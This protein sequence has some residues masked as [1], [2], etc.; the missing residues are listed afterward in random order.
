M[1]TFLFTSESVNE[2]HPDKLCDQ[3]SDAVLDACLAQDPDSKVACETCTKTN[4]V[5]VFGEIT[6][7]ANVDYEKIVRDTCRSIGFTSA[8][9]GLDADHC[10]VLV[11]IEQQS[12]DIAQGVHGH[13]TK[14]PEEIGAGDQGHMF[15]YATDETP[16]LMPLSHVLATKLGAKLTEVRKNGTC[17]WLRPDGKTQVTVEYYNENGAMVPVRVHTVLIS[18][19]HDETVTND[20]IAADLKQHVIKPVIPDKYLDDK[21]IFHLNPSGRFVIGGPHGDA[22]LTG[23]KIIID[24]YG[25]WGAHGGG[26]FSGKD[27]TKVDRSGAYIVRQAAKSIVASGLARRCIV[28]VSYAIGVPEPLSVFVDSYGTGKIPDKEILKIV[29]ENFDFRPGMISINLDLKRGG[30]GRFLKTAAY[31]H[32]GRDDPDF[33]WEIGGQLQKSG[34]ERGSKRSGGGSANDDGDSDNMRGHKLE[35]GHS[36]VSNVEIEKSRVT[37]IANGKE[38]TSS[39]I[40]AFDASKLQKLRNKGSKKT[41]IVVSKGSKPDPKKK[42]TKKNRVWDD[43]PPESKLDFTDPAGGNGSNIEVEAT[44]H[45]ENLEPALKSLKNRLMTKNVAEEIVEKLCESVAA[46]L[47][48]KKLASFT[49][50]SSIVQA[51]ME[52]ALVRILTPRRSIDILRDVLMHLAPRSKR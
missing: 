49:M 1:E 41:D 23:R 29:K 31:G 21:T 33:T 17:P 38:N 39:N 20:E 10:K 14:R 4:M 50:I 28:Q 45:G 52:E 5:M 8:D 36:N 43:S 12:P 26:A 18:T 9:V 32:F 19:Q 6:T 3:V 24:T 35:N 30:N 44:D 40:G 46:S 48:G 27:P 25:G 11:N 42:T 37:G 51:A 34:F 7:K 16:E 47:E 2:G 13:L 22:G 15:G